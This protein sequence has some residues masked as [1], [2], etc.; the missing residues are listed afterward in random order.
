[1][2]LG[3][4]RGPCAQGAGSA[5]N[6]LRTL[7]WKGGHAASGEGRPSGPKAP[8]SPRDRDAPLTKPRWQR[9]R[10]AARRKARRGRRASLRGNKSAPRGAVRTSMAYV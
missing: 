8:I 1:M 2:S 9:W 10:R 3:Q 6:E 7:N 5:S 4:A